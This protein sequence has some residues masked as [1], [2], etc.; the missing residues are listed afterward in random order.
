MLTDWE[1]DFLQ[2][3]ANRH[4]ISEKQIAVLN[5]ITAKVEA[6]ARVSVAGS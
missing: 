3:I 2:S 5:R 4:R 1:T 6:F